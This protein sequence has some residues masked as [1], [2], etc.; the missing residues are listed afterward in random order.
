[1]TMQLPE[2]LAY[3]KARLEERGFKLVSEHT[4]ASFGD[5]SIVLAETPLAV[6]FIA[7]RGQWFVELSCESW[8]DWF[9]PDV[10]EACLNDGPVRDEPAALDAQAEFITENLDHLARV[11]TQ[12]E[13][14]LRT[15]LNE[16]RA[17]RARQR[18][19]RDG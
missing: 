5:R 9:D 2:P 7:E 14:G 16:K 8:D 1:M 6:R 11:V 19:K 13:S 10:W 12:S 15:C 18:L 4:S 17:A 3:L